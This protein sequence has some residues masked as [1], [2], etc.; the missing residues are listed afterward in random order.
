[1][2]HDEMIKSMNRHGYLWGLWYLAKDV[3]ALVGEA[4][5]LRR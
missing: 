4:C 3:V 2:D 5:T 1:M